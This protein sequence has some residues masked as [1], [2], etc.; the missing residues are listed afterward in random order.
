[1]IDKAMVIII[2]MYAISFSILGVQYEIAD[3]YHKDIVSLVDVKDSTGAVTIPKG[4]A[5]RSANMWTSLFNTLAGC[6]S[7]VCAAARAAAPYARR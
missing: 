5:I 1:M 6:Y 7:S 2:F 4:T 3:V